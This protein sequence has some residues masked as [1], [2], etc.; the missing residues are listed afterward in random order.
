[1]KANDLFKLT[2]LKTGEVVHCMNV[3]NACQVAGIVPS[4][5]YYFMLG[6]V[7]NDWQLSVIDGSEIKWK[8]IYKPE[9][10]VRKNLHVPNKYY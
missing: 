2:N 5:Q 10:K 6:R 9:A 3:F 7:Y 1:M 4:K 8:D